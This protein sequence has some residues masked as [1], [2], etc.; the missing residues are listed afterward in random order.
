MVIKGWGC[1][2]GNARWDYDLMIRLYTA[3]TVLAWPF[4]RLIMRHRVRTGKEDGG[5]VAERFGEASIPRPT[6]PVIWVHAASVGETMSIL[7]L[8]TRFLGSF[9]L[10][11]VLITTGTVSS[12]KILEEK[13][14]N[15]LRLPWY[16]T[17]LI[18]FSIYI[19]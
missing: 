16:L 5:R 2:R 15:H 4:A 11:T 6:G 10:A 8:V 18:F 1:R 12:A 9:R 7:P 14:S 13:L 3:A 19:C 17:N